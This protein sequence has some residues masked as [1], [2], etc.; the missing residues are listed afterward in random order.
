[1]PEVLVPVVTSLDPVRV[2]YTTDDVTGREGTSGLTMCS[3]FSGAGGS[4]LGYR[5]AGF[6]VL[7]ANEF[8]PDAAANAASGRST[9]TSSANNSVRWTCSKGHR[10]AR[11]SRR[12]VNG[13][14][15][16]GR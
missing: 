8:D 5:L 2:P 16:G 9:S 7:W 11:S 1:M 6:K 3:T 12:P 13:P 15:R 4:T 10:R 14:S